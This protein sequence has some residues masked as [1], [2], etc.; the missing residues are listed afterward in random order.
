MSKK[1]NKKNDEKPKQRKSLKGSKSKNEVKP[2]PRNNSKGSKLKN[3]NE[4]KSDFCP[5]D[6]M[7]NMPNPEHQ[8][9]LDYLDCDN[10]S[11]DL[12]KTDLDIL[13]KL[14]EKGNKKYADINSKNCPEN[15]LFEENKLISMK[16]SAQDK[17][18]EAKAKQKKRIL[19]DSL[20]QVNADD[21]DPGRSYEMSN[22]DNS[23]V[24]KSPR[25]DFSKTDL[26]PNDAE[27]PIVIDDDENPTEAQSE[28]TKI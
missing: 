19:I 12:R 24:Q 28:E 13:A 26:L 4:A 25:D 2:K 16:P 27:N 20:I 10:D 9:N 21:I 11:I 8:E 15:A 23:E 6:F 3:P 1:S 14:P 17:K 5:K 7:Y 22:L 18:R